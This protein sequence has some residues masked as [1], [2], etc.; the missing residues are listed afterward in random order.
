MRAAAKRSSRRP[1]RITSRRSSS[2]PRNNALCCARGAARE[3]TCC[4]P[5]SAHGQLQYI[6]LPGEDA[7]A[8]APSQSQSQRL[9]AQ[10]QLAPDSERVA[11]PMSQRGLAQSFDPNAL[12]GQSPLVNHYAPLPAEDASVAAEPEPVDEKK[13]RRR[14]RTH[15]TNE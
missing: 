14:T 8:S 1:R 4:A 10:T 15:N 13:R 5:R 3:L 12:G 2:A 11:P 7:Y 9:R 6:A